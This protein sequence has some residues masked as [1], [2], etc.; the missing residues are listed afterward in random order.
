MS[1]FQAGRD[2]LGDPIPEGHGKRGRPP[3]IPT[4][5]NRN[6]V[7]LLLA[8]G[9]RPPRIAAALRITG[10]TLRKHYFVELRQADEA[11]HAL[12][13]E[14]L[15]LVYEAAKGGNVGAMKELGRM[16]DKLNLVLATPRPDAE[17][18]KRETL[19]KKAAATEAAQT[20]H[21]DTGWSKLLN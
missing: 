2:L 13:A 19:G 14:H 6:K 3:H 21:K 17:P 1:D 8:F 18:D 5:R 16:L 11:K 15:S 12:E 10:D 4:D 9:W 20:A 7:R